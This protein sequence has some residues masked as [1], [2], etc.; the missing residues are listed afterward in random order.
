MTNYI[1]LALC[2][3]VLISYFFDITSKYTKIPGV[4]LMICLGIVIRMLADPAGLKVPNLEPVLPVLG[5]IGLIMIVME[6]S[7]DLKL[8]KNKI[9][10]I[11]GSIAAA[12]ILLVLFVI[13]FTFILVRFMEFES[14]NSLLIAIT[15]GIIGS[16]VAISSSRG[17]NSSHKEFIVYESSISDI[18]GILLFDFI[19][20]NH[21]NIG[22]GLLTFTLKGIITVILAFTL[23]AGLAFLL[24]KTRYHVNYVIIMT[25]V[26]M[27]YILGKI[28]HL[29]A[30]FLVLVFGLTLS[31]NKLI[32][33]SI[34]RRWVD[35]EKFRNDVSAFKKIMGELTFLIRSFFFIMFGYYTS[36]E[37]IF[38]LSNLLTA[39]IITIGILLLRW[40]YFATV[41]KLP[42]VPLVFF[43]P[44][45]LITILLFMNIPV[46]LR[47]PLITEEVVTL[48]IFMTILVMMVGNI[49]NSHTE[50]RV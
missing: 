32:E 2:L 15:L 26:V 4:V 35:F 10:M 7:L 8:Q 9:K 36:L 34:V 20:I 16:T 14:V 37:G 13:I 23:T 45:G 48:I 3:I 17:L 31:N 41:L 1:I 19:L 5:T 29:P 49:L 46:S 18:I 6:A 47:I 24:H 40:I 33:N 50:T 25:S 11:Y 28:A 22:L 44:R 12:I 43:A 39:A 38:N 42:A 21:G 30:L 27:I